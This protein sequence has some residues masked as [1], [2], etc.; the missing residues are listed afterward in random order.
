MVPHQAVAVALPPKPS[1]NVAQDV[2][3]SRAISIVVKDRFLTVATRRHVIK[4][5]GVFDS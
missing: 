4:S 5:T 1:N 3:K 2:Q